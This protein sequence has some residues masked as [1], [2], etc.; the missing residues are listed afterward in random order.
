METLNQLKTVERKEPKSSL[1]VAVCSPEWKS[2]K[3][4]PFRVA[5]EGGVE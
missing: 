3:V 2:L 1:N 4:E 5:R